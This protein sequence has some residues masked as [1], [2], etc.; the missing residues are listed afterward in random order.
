MS[1]DSETEKKQKQQADLESKLFVSP[2]ADPMASDKLCK[3]LLKFIKKS[4]KAKSVR[5]GVKET[6]K[7]VKKEG[8]GYCFKDLILL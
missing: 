3:K 7:A 5:R 6:V 1:S 4:M 8:K 2:I